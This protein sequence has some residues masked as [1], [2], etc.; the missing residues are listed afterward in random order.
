[1]AMTDSLSDAPNTRSATLRGLLQNARWALHFA[2]TTNAL[3]LAGLI[4]VAAGRGSVPAGLAL[5]ARGLINAA[6]TALGQGTRDIVPLVPWLAVGLGLTVLEAVSQRADRFFAQRLYDDLNLRITTDILAH[7][8]TLDTAC[9]ED[10]PLREVLERAQ[11]NTA[12]HVSRFVADALIAGTNLIQTVS[13]VGILLY[14]DP[15]IVLVLGPFSLPYL[16]FQWR[17]ARAQ[18][19]EEQ[20]RATKR[21]W[22]DYFVSRLMSPRSVPEVKLLGL[23]PLLIDRFRAVM[24]EFRDRNRS[25][26][27]QSLAGG[28][29]FGVL[30]TIAFYAIFARVA[31]RTLEAILTVG[32]LAIFAGATTR[33]RMTLERS[34]VAVSSAMERTLYIS[35]FVG[36][37]SLEPRI[38]GGRG[39]VP[40]KTHGELEFAGVSF[41]YPGA[42]DP[43]L[44]D[45]SLQIRPG[46][47]V[48]LVGENGAGKT[49]FAKLVARLYDPDQGRILLDGVDL[50]ELDLDY[51]QSQIAFVFQEFSRYEATAADNIAYG[52]WR[53]LRYNRE[54]VERIAVLANVHAMIK[55]LPQGYD[56]MLGRLFGGHDLSSGGWQAL[57][58][59]RAFARDAPLLILDE[60]TSSLDA[61]AEAE[62]LHRF[63]ELTRGRTTILI[64]HRFSTVSMADRIL[65]MERGRIV[66]SGTHDELLARAGTYAG[67]YDLYSRHTA[68]RSKG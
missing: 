64:S 32:D 27:L 15:L 51:L 19:T 24:M 52:D 50:R 23:A 4:L 31:Y 60:P 11:Q 38:A 45:V 39:V 63:R 58:L 56:T 20:S 22:T 48:A 42:S 36:F 46:E 49:T 13:L 41:T 25:I 18:F 33:L 62:L 17:L 67:L 3:L 61:R 59:A 28:S 35:N 54:Q 65:V 40:A 8:A 47:T 43:A 53:R 29:L 44:H 5:A 55:E 1:M 7:A 66:E 34:I 14:I 16:L 37:L 9:F 26:Y 2:W 21:R 10:P 57:A 30:T 68:S 6:V 12:D